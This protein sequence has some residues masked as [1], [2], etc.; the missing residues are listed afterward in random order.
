MTIGERIRNRRIAVG[1]SVDELAEKIGKN[2]ATVYRYEGDEIE[3]LP[4][5]VLEPLSIALD[6]TPAYLL[7]IEEATDEKGEEETTHVQSIT[8]CGNP[9]GEQL[10]EPNSTIHGLSKEEA[11]IIKNYRILDDEAKKQLSQTVRD[12]TVSHLLRRIS[13]KQQNQARVASYG[14]G[15]KEVPPPDEKDMEWVRKF[16]AENRFEDEDE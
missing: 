5:T 10:N 7:G 16:I 13:L 15:A 6:C 2:R 8:T 12:I 3:N 4:A 1:L 11:E 14:H 9:K